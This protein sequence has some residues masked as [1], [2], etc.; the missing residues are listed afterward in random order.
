MS[1]EETLAKL[2]ELIR[3]KNVV[4]FVGAGISVAPPA[5][6]PLGDEIKR[7]LLKALCASRGLRPDFTRF[8][9]LDETELLEVI[10]KPCVG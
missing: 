10:S 4:A 1:N 7:N 6:A 5:G 8:A 9:S 3:G 2:I